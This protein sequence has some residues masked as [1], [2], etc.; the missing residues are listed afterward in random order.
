MVD[1]PEKMWCRSFPKEADIRELLSEAASKGVSAESLRI[2]RRMAGLNP[3]TRLMHNLSVLLALCQ[4]SEIRDILSQGLDVDE[5]RAL[6][7]L[8]SKDLTVPLREVAHG[9]FNV[10]ERWIVLKSIARLVREAAASA[11]DYV[12]DRPLDS[13]LGIKESQNV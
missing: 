10:H 4:Q 7:E 8:D 6:M 13:V 1:Q 3:M 9:L 5:R 12:S 11:D 2:L